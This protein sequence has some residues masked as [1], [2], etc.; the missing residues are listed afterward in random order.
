MRCSAGCSSSSRGTDLEHRLIP[1]RVVVPAGVALLV[2]RTIDD[3]SAAWLLSGLAAGLFLFVF[4]LIYPRGIGMGD[5]KLAAAMG[6]ALGTAVAV[7][8]FVGFAA[9]FVPPRS[10]SFGAAAPRSR[11]ASLS[12]RFSLSEGSS[13]SSP[14]LRSSTGTAARATEPRRSRVQ[15]GCGKG[16]FMTR[17]CHAPVLRGPTSRRRPARRRRAARCCG[18]DP[19]RRSDEGDR[20]RGPGAPGCDPRRVA[21]GLRPR[22]RPALAGGAARLPVRPRWDRDRA[23]GDGPGGSPRRTAAQ[24][25][26]LERSRLPRRAPRGV[27]RGGRSAARRACV[28]GVFNLE[29][30]RSL[31]PAAVELLATFGL[32]ARAGCRAAARGEETRPSRR[33]LGLFVYLGSLREP[34]EIATLG[35]VSLSRVLDIERSEVWT[36]DEVGTPSAL[37]AWSADESDRPALVQAELEAARSLVDPSAICQLVDVGRAGRRLGQAG[38]S[39]FRSVR[40]VRSWES[41]SPSRAHGTVSMPTCSTRRRCSPHTSRRRSTA[42]L[43]LRRERRSALTDPLDGNSQPSRAR[44]AAR[45]GAS[46][47]A[48]ATAPAQRPRVRRRRLQGDQRPGGT[49][50]RRHPP[51]RGRRRALRVHPRDLGRRAARRRRVLRGAPRRGRGRGGRARP[52]RSAAFSPTASPR[53][54]IRSI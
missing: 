47:R 11:S 19:S 26:R 44:G 51:A 53:P 27:E 39:G 10:W 25:R 45:R 24:H 43:A 29:S 18:R 41:S 3:P 32:R 21:L 38:W 28:I 54:A 9:A 40:T 8:L 50:V 33:S 52:R 17:E 1:N 2:A 22:A 14:E 23:R 12:D 36:W 35:A 46:P 42:A 37:A 30:E 5:V 20:L 7:A 34:S 6:C 15:G 13:P 49:R 31:P 16:R 48:G 4:V